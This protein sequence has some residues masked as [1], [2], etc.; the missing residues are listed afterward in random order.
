MCGELTVTNDDNV[1]TPISRMPTQRS[2]LCEQAA[3]ATPSGDY[4]TVEEVTQLDSPPTGQTTSEIKD[5]RANSVSR[6]THVAVTAHREDQV[7]GSAAIRS[8]P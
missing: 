4:P 6:H 8:S 2:R 7:Y 3:T 1:E 5:L